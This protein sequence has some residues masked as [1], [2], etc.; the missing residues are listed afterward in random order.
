MNKNNV[1]ETIIAQEIAA[2]EEWNKGNPSGYLNIFASDI[3]YFDP[4]TEKRIDGFEGMKVLYESLRGKI[5][6]DKYEM[7]EPVVQV[8]GE[9]AVLTYNL[10]SY[11]GDKLYKWNCTEVYRYEKEN[12]W[13]IIHNHWSLVKPIG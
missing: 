9:I 2:L 8:A 4:F 3:T 13:K 7:V 1:E 6:A 11:A 5:R 12:Q 10:N